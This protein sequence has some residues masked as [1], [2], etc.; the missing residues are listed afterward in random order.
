MNEV[1]ALKYEATQD[2]RKG[3]WIHTFSGNKFYAFD[4]RPE[5]INIEDIAHALSLTCRYSGHCNKF[6]SV[7]EHSIILSRIVDP[8]FALEA[9]LHDSPEAYLTD[10]PR[11]IKHMFKDY[12]LPFKELEDA[13]YKV[14]AEKYGANPEIPEEVHELDYHIVADEATV[15]FDPVPHWCQWYNPIGAKLA[16]WDWERAEREFLR[17][18]KEL[19][20]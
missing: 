18:F 4:P 11:P 2:E 20:Q 10:I 14:I 9:L 16:C 6:Y 12:N 8:K 19:T 17:R 15:L 3:L 5:D 7:A 13:I 1:E